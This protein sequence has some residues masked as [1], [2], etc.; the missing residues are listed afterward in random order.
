[1][2]ANCSRALV[3]VAAVALLAVLGR[4]STAAAQEAV[5]DVRLTVEVSPSV[6]HITDDGF[7]S[8]LLNN[9]FAYRLELLRQNGFSV[10]E[11]DLRGPGP[12]YRC[13][14][15]IEAIRKDARV[16]SIQVES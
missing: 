15:V 7:M 9:H 14:S 12:Y 16:Q 1:M 2:N 10:I 11:V 13:E 5:C 8:S 4:P 3:A 6:P